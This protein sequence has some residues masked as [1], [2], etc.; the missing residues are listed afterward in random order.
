M[1]LCRGKNTRLVGEKPSWSVLKALNHYRHTILYVLPSS[2]VQ[3][4]LE[5]LTFRAILEEENFDYKKAHE[6]LNS[7]HCYEK[8]YIAGRF[9]TF[10]AKVHNKGQDVFVLLRSGFLLTPMVSNQR[11]VDFIASVSSTLDQNKCKLAK[12]WKFV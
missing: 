5:D 4:H 2:A 3:S 12:F 10:R 7:K 6:S 1:L 8:F 9:Y 11:C